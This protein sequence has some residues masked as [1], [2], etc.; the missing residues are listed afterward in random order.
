MYENEQRLDENIEV[1]MN[2]YKDIWDRINELAFVIEVDGLF[3]PKCFIDAN[4]KVCNRLGYSKE[5]FIKATPSD[6]FS[7]NKKGN[8]LELY[9]DLI[10]KRCDKVD[11]ILKSK[12][13][14]HI[15]VEAN[16]FLFTH[17]IKKYILIIAI[18]VTE[19]KKI[20]KNITR[21][22]KGIPDIIKV[23]N[24]DYTIAFFNEAGYIFY[25]K[26][27]QEVK[28]KMCY[29]VLDRKQKCIDCSFEEVMQTKQMLTR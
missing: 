25:N 27:P 21:I 11:I 14:K 15:Y 16:M 8:I 10:Y 22:I 2:N 6:I 9:R 4:N 28:G 17:N 1:N 24:P 7:F 13:E 18:D 5:N 19:N 23:Y 26:T 3:V 12:D 29:E 20:E